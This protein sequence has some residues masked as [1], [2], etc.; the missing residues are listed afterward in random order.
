VVRAITTTDGFEDCTSPTTARTCSTT[1]IWQRHVH[2]HQ[3][4]AASQGRVKP[5]AP[6]ALSSTTIA[7]AILIDG[8][9]LC[10][11]RFIDDPA[12]AAPNC[13]WKGV[14]VMC[15]PQ[16]LPGAKNILYHKPRRGTFEDRHTKSH[17]DKPTGH[18]PSASPPSITMTTAGP[19]SSSPA[20]PP[21]A[22]FTTTIAMAPSRT[23]RSPRAA[24]NEDGHAQREWLYCRRLQRRWPPGHFSKTNFSDDTATLYRNNGDGTFDDATY[25]PDSACTPNTSVGHDVL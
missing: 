9:Q 4:K 14:P 8:R 15:G 20:T 7:T 24:F 11:F 12:P 3:R 21:P 5:G 18:T 25:K 6:A 10:R 13:L 23:S 16:G 1:T 22:S 17:I 19:T 2:R